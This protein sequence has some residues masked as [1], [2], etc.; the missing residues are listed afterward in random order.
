VD[1]KLEHNPLKVQELGQN[2]ANLTMRRVELSEEERRLLVQVFE[3]FKRQ[4]LDVNN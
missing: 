4:S 2:I 1:E 3:I